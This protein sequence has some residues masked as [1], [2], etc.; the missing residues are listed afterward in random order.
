MKLL[1]SL[2]GSLAVLGSAQASVISYD[3]TATI[4]LINAYGPH[5]HVPTHPSSGTLAG[6]TY[7][8]GDLVH[9][10]IDYDTETGLSD[11]QN[12]PP[13][14]GTSL[15]YQSPG[16]HNVL[17]A[18][19]NGG[20]LMPAPGPSDETILQIENDVITVSGRDLFALLQY[21]RHGDEKQVSTLAFFDPTRTMLNGAGIPDSLHLG[22]TILASVDTGY[23]F[24]DGSVLY[25]AA[26]LTSLT[27]SAPVPE[28][29][30]YLLLLAG[31]AMILFKCRS[32]LLAKL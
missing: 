20:Q 21:S 17:A 25:I 8:L 29:S 9:G 22:P 18:T 11:S 10:H 24:A 6:T 13:A 19:A 27:V 1:I 31:L 14:S 26:E 32:R 12:N 15:F 2:L 28:P 4:K 3:F 30:S 23:I 16:A 7:S 5:M